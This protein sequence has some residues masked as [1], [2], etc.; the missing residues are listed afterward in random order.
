MQFDVT[1]LRTNI[2][3]DLIC[4]PKKPTW[5]VDPGCAWSKMELQMGKI[6]LQSATTDKSFNNSAKSNW[7]KSYKPKDCGSLRQDCSSSTSCSRIMP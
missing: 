3:K 4:S 1:Q 7:R 5:R 6:D 2:G